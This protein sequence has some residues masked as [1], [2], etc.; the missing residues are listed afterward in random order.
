MSAIVKTGSVL[1]HVYYAGIVAFPVTE[2]DRV[3]YYDSREKKTYVTGFNHSRAWRAA[4][5]F[6]A[7]N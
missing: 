1:D 6:E 2:D 4:L 7:K 3:V 5:D